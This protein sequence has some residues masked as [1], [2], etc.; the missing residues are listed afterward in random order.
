VPFKGTDPS[1]TFVRILREEPVPLSRF[2]PD[3]PPALQA[4][5]NRAL[6]KNAHD[7]YQSAEEFGFDL[8]GIQNDLKVA[9]VADS[10]KRA[11]SA[12]QRGDLERVRSLLQDVLRLDRHNERANRLLREVRQTIQQQQRSSQVGQIRSQA[13]VALAGG[14]YE[15]ALACADQALRLDPTDTETIQLCDQIRNAISRAKAVR[16]A[17]NRAETALFAGDFDEAKD[18]V[19]ESLRLDPTDSGA[20]ALAAMINKE[21]AERSRRHQ[22][23]GFVDQARRGIAERK[24]T[25]AID[26]LH[27]AEELDPTDSNVRELLQWA[28]RGQEQENKRRYL[29]DITNQIENALHGGDFSSACT[30]SEMGLQ[31]FPEDP[32]LLR[33]RAISEKQRDIGERRR[34]V[35]DQS[36]A[37]KALTD[38][39]KLLDAVQ[40][41]TEALR[42]YPGEPNLESLLA[43]TKAAIERQQIERE[44]AARKRAMQR[45]EAEARSQLTQQVLNWSIELRRALDARAA[46]ADI[47][48]TSKE[49]RLV[50]DTRQIE[51]HARDAASLVLNELNARIRA[52]DQAMIDLEQLQR[53]FERSLDSPAL[54]EAESR[55]LSAK[56]AFPNESSIQRICSDLTDSISKAREERNRSISLLGELAQT[57][58]AK[59]TRELMSL[60]EKARNL[61]AGVASDPRAGALLQQIDSS[62]NRRFAR[63]AEL[64][65]DIAVLHAGLSKVQSL[66]EIDRIRERGRATAALDS[67]DDELAERSRKLQGEAQALR[68]SMESLLRDMAALARRVASATTIDDAEGLVPQVK[69]LA[70]RRPDFQTLQEAATHIFAEVQGRRIEHDLIVQELEAALAALPLVETDEELDASATRARECLELHSRDATIQTLSRQIVDHVETILQNRA[71]LRARH[72]ECDN[73]LQISRERLDDRDLDGALDVLLSVEE[74]NPDRVDLHVQISILRKA[75]EQRRAEQ[76]QLEQEQRAREQAEAEARARRAAIEQAIQEARELLD[77]GLNDESVQRLRSALEREPGH[78]GLEA[79]LQFTQAEI[80]RR[81][82]EHERLERERIAREQA[83]AE[84][85][86]RREA[87]ELAIIEARELLAQ[88]RGDESLQRLRLALQHDSQNPELQKALDSTQAEI[89]RQRAEQERLERERLERERAEAQ[90]RARKAAA[91][92]AV[93]EAWNLLAQ[94]Q[95]EAS[96]QTL[97]SALERDPANTEL[98]FELQMV[99]EELGRRRAEQERVERERIAREK[100]EAEARARREAAGLAIKEARELLAQGRWDESVEKLRL[101]LQQDPQSA[102]LRKALDSTEAEVARQRAEQERLEQERLERERLERERVEREKAEAEARARREAAK[103]A[104]KEARE[105]LAQGRNDE[106]VEKLRLALQQDPQSPELRKALDSTEAEIARQRAEQERLEQERLEHERLERER[107]EREKAEAEARARRE[108]AKLAIKEAR[109]LLAQGRNNESVEKLRRALQQDPQSAELRKALDSTEAEIARQRAEQERLE[110]ERLERERLERER[111]ERE[112]AEA[113][114]RARREA[115]KLAIKEARELLAQGRNDESVEKLRLALQQDPQSPELRKA[116]DSTEAEIA[117][118]RAEQE[119]IERERARQE[120]IERERAEA[121]ARARRVAAAQAIDRARKL[122]GKGKS[123]ESLE[124]LRDA[125]QRDPQNAELTSEVQSLEAELAR[126]LA[127]QLRLEQERAERERLERERAEAEARLRTEK[128]QQAIR[129]AR[130]LQASGRM[131]ESIQRVRSGLEL[132]PKDAELSSELESIQKEID[133]QR[134]EKERLERERLERERVAREKAEAE[135]RARRAAADRAIKDARRQLAQGNE[136]ASLLCLQTALERD[137]EN[138]NLL[139]EL[140]WFR[141]EITRRSEDRERLER[142]RLERERIAREKAEAEARARREAAELAIKEA[143]DL[144]AQGRN[145]E[146][147]RRLRLA[148]QQDPQNPELRKALDS[149]QAEVARQRAEQERLEQERLERERLERERIAREKAEA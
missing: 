42:R 49:L 3:A 4:V 18:A 29:Q 142:E 27:R 130:E 13:Q 25:D 40:V 98:Y 55:M 52:R 2:I 16:E 127:E 33:L 102:E 100:A 36:L 65:R 105:L 133:R 8:L 111:V 131:E 107:V 115:A 112:K 50:L 74:Q 45:A 34:F 104:I 6:A 17:L 117:R 56:A 145:D 88:S 58:E 129:E 62:I 85:R 44:E 19:E 114:A 126:Q 12:M 118:Q 135:A 66:D 31:R 139:S 54:N 125:I 79:A 123:E 7:R 86:A 141:E 116:L 83:E 9:T 51:D 106:S 69:E 15:E 136:E 32:T 147:V 23:Q 124:C 26:A 108:A 35:H 10:L 95:G 81:R 78:D 120:Q 134:A 67:T 97:R 140:Q 21:L 24:F 39:D 90:E 41:L 38:E 43:I 113:E 82:E 46:L 60:Q 59:P 109:E 89:A 64:L 61:A 77:Q 22:V 72:V 99:Q 53:A 119:R 144:L 47:L 28:Q 63:R 103:L 11:E 76:E 87:A 91:D 128:V 138:S 71:E 110:Q 146:S 20:R 122:F 121:E 68:D 57:A 70:D 80:S 92:Q 30:I 96:V 93:E 84:A 148:L 101:G 137:P 48:K 149:T 132:Y 5:M 1:S 14:Q 73:A 75:I 143:G 37:V 94:G